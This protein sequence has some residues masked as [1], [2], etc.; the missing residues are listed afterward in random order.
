[1]LCRNRQETARKK[2]LCLKRCKKGWSLGERLFRFEGPHTAISVGDCYRK[3][4]L[5]LNKGR[6]HTAVVDNPDFD[7]WSKW[8]HKWKLKHR[9]LRDSVSLAFF[10]TFIKMMTSSEQLLNASPKPLLSYLTSVNDS[11]FN[12][13]H[14]LARKQTRGVLSW[15]C[16]TLAVA[17]WPRGWCYRL[18]VAD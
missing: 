8:F 4:K 13:R 6:C 10:F 14:L 9:P 2:Q 18:T 15:V 7:M 5:V 11:P 12:K 17:G 3:F 1:M 16:V